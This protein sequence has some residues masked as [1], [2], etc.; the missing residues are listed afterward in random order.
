[1]APTTSAFVLQDTIDDLRIKYSN[2][3]GFYNYIDSDDQENLE[4]IIV[5]DKRTGEEKKFRV[6]KL[7]ADAYTRKHIQKTFYSGSEMYNAC[8]CMID[9]ANNPLLVNVKPILT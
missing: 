2:F 7:W 8:Q 4:Y 9:F 6:G 1:M 3:V 5:Y